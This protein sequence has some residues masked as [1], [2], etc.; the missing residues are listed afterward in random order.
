MHMLFLVSWRYRANGGSADQVLSDTR[1]IFKV[2]EKW[3]PS[4]DLTF[5]AFVGRSDGTG[6]FA[7]IE[8]DNLTALLEDAT[9][10][11]TFFEFEHTPVIDIGEA[12]PAMVGALEWRESIDQ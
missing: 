4:P 8:T 3:A 9:K 5:K 12:V 6:G 2:Y 11:G 7:L 10:F 1:Q